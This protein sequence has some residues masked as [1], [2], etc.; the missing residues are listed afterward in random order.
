MMVGPR[1]ALITGACRG[2]GKSIAQRLSKDGFHVMLN[3]LPTQREAL[4]AVERDIKEKGG[5]AATYFA[6]VSGETEVKTMVA[7]TVKLLGSLDVVSDQRDL[8]QFTL[9]FSLSRWLQMRGC[10]SPDHS[11]RV[12]EA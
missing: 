6:D 12:S 7:D 5:K 3:D 10:L 4:V 8:L 2:I 11:L 1:V 9:R